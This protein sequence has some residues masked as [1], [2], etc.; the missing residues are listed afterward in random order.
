MRTA[1]AVPRGDTQ[2]TGAPDL[3]ASYF[4]QNLC[5]VWPRNALAH[6]R[7]NLAGVLAGVGKDH[8]AQHSTR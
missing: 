7:D 6:D 8:C 5:N 3:H 1:Q 4:R 2:K